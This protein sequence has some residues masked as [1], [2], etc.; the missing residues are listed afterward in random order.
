[1][2]TSGLIFTGSDDFCMTVYHYSKQYLYIYFQ[3]AALEM[4]AD[5][6]EMVDDLVEMEI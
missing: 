4:V 2:V 5:L 1:M 3:V 6:V